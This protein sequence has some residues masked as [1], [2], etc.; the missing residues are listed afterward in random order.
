MWKQVSAQKFIKLKIIKLNL[1]I[2][3]KTKYSIFS[4]K[5][6]NSKLLIQQLNLNDFWYLQFSLYLIMN[7]K[8]T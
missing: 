3:P 8:H 4:L 1:Y 5:G 6:I 7:F 2:Y